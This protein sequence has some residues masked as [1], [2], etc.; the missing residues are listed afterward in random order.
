MEGRSPHFEESFDANVNIETE[1]QQ[2]VQGLETEGANTCS[3]KNSMALCQKPTTVINADSDVELPVREGPASEACFSWSRN[4]GTSDS[5]DDDE[6]F[7]RCFKPRTKKKAFRS[8]SCIA[9]RRIE[10]FLTTRYWK[11]APKLKDCEL[12]RS[13][14][15]LINCLIIV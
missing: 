12:S 8:P 5:R 14:R 3:S 9:E 7:S 1:R 6:K 13:G 10:K 2:E 15:Q 11:A 4:D